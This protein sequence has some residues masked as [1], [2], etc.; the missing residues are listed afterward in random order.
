MNFSLTTRL[1]KEGNENLLVYTIACDEPFTCS[2]PLPLGVVD[3]YDMWEVS[4]AYDPTGVLQ[5]EASVN[6]GAVDCS[7]PIPEGAGITTTLTKSGGGS[8]KESCEEYTGSPI[9]G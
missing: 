4:G 6:L 9:C 8:S 3:D 1:E 7:A 2:D 5:V